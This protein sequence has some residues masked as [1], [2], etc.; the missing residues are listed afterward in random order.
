[1]SEVTLDVQ[2]PTVYVRFSRKVS[3]EQYGSREASVSVPVVLTG[4]KANDAIAIDD[5]AELARA[6]VLDLVEIET[7]TENGKTREVAAAPVVK[8]TSQAGPAYSSSEAPTAG[9]S[10][11]DVAKWG[12]PDEERACP[13]C[14]GPTFNNRRAKA[15]PPGTKGAISP[16][17][18]EFKCRK[19]KGDDKC[20]GVIWKNEL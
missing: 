7:V 4:D 10:G 19:Y 5:A 16:K 17:A 8:A 13:I 15:L 11:F 9:S 2:E 14:N 6:V 3:P 12:D 1:M 20:D 18:P